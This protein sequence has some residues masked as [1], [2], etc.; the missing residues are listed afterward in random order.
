[1]N[2]DEF[3]IILLG[4][5]HVDKTSIAIRQ[6]EN[7]FSHSSKPTIGANQLISKVKVNNR[8]IELVL[9]DTAG[10]EEFN[11]LIPMYLRNSSCAI[12]VCAANNQQTIYNIPKWY[13]MLEEMTV[14]PPCIVA[15]NKVDLL[16]DQV[17][18]V[19][20]IRQKLENRYKN[21]IFVSALT[22]YNIG[23]LFDTVA[24]NCLMEKVPDT[25]EFAVMQSQKRNSCC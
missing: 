21:I 4:D 2:R 16:A 25:S 1:M 7:F 13:T 23:L 12:I 3:K 9:W 17:Q 11:A 6:S 20:N 10:Q 24:Q 15:I 5:T 18:D 19:E 8:E 14:T 22:G